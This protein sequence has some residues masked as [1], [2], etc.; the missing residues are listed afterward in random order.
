MQCLRYVPT[1]PKDVYGLGHPAPP[2]ALRKAPPAAK[3]PAPAAMRAAPA[4]MPA[5]ASCHGANSCRLR[6]WTC[7]RSQPERVGKEFGSSEP[8]QRTGARL[9]GSEGRP[10]RGVARNSS[11]YPAGRCWRFCRSPLSEDFRS[12]DVR[13]TL[14]ARD[15]QYA[16]SMLRSRTVGRH[17]SGN[18]LPFVRRIIEIASNLFAVPLVL[19]VA[20][21][22]RYSYDV[23]PK[24]RDALTAL[25]SDTRIMQAIA[26]GFPQSCA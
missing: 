10:E 12:D 6:S 1:A 18:L 9:R 23:W 11:S 5:K 19:K 3:M 14:W 4:V 22:D 8:F 24:N 25:V 26:A 15:R 17:G 7:A 13:T 20:L 21:L 2:I 16:N